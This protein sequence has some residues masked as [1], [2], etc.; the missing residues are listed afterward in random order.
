MKI[1]IEIK[2]GVLCGVHTDDKEQDIKVV[3]CDHDDAAQEQDGDGFEFQSTK[4]C[5]ELD[6]N[7]SNLRD[8]F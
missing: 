2:G 1:Y 8:I 4:N 5:N 6:N 7:R 3:L